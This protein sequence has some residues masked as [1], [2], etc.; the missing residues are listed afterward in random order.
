MF[1]TL[2]FLLSSSELLEGVIGVDSDSIG[3]S[4]TIPFG[5]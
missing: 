1:S 3:R 4:P 5:G 2:G